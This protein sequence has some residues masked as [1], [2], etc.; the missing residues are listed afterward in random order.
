LGKF[1]TALEW[2]R[3][4]YSLTTWNILQPFGTFYGHSVIS[5]QFGIFAPILGSVYISAAVPPLSPIARF[6][7]KNVVGASV[8][9]VWC[10][11]KNLATLLTSP[12][13][14]YIEYH[15]P[16]AGAVWRGEMN[17]TFTV[18]IAYFDFQPW[19]VAP[20]RSIYTI[21]HVWDV[22]C[23]TT[24]KLCGID[25]IFCRAVRHNWC[26][27]TGVSLTSVGLCK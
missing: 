26:H 21:R 2:K 18:F 10:V 12:D 5:W 9:L 25:P 15:L 1:W 17:S 14:T 27:S 11:K 7:I 13:L 8:V 23:D 3:L 6:P 22:S 16:P 4:V 24:Q 20:S 19:H